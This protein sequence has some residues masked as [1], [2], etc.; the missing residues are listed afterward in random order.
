MASSNLSRNGLE[1]IIQVFSRI[2]LENIHVNVLSLNGE[3]KP[4]PEWRVQ[5]SA[6]MA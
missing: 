1:K 3:L 4:Q 5:T 2:G 6:A